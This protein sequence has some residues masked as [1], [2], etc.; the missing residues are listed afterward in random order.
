MADAGAERFHFDQHRVLV[1]I[2][3]DFL[4]HQAMAG[5]FAL[6]PQLVARAAVEGGDSRSPPSCESFL[7]HE[8]DHQDA[9]RLRDPE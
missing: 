8:A 7:V 4:H 2:G 6:E 3:R 9:A 5:G 1:A